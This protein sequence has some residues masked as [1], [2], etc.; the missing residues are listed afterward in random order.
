MVRKTPPTKWAISWPSPSKAK[1][2]QAPASQSSGHFYTFQK[3][4]N[5]M[6]SKLQLIPTGEMSREAWLS[7]RHTGLGASEVGCILGLDDYTSSLELYYYKIGEVPKFD[8]ESMASFIGQIDE[9]KIAR[10]WQYWEG[11]EE[12]MIRNF[13]EN[14]IVRRCQRVNAYVRNPDYPWLYISLDRKINKHGDLDE[15]TLELKTIGGWEANKWEAGLPPKYI[16]QVQTQILVAEFLYGEMALLEDNRKFFVYPIERN[17]NIINHIITRTKDFWDRVEKGRRL[18]NEKYDAMTKFNQR[19]VDECTHEIDALAPEPDGT[20]AYSDYLKKRFDKP[21]SAE[22]KGTPSELENA[23]AQRDAADRLKEVTETKLLHENV[24]K[25]SMGDICQVLDFG[26]DGKVYWS[27]T[28]T[29]SRIFRNKLK[30]G[31]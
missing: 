20:L 2:L 21:S 8:T 25:K 31:V 27:K 1:L 3:T 28:S 15:G 5:V 14:K 29:G 19:R 12:S 17:E 13:R 30:T 9:D 23:I 7:Y 24:L 10:L 18:V 22:R 6:K 11:D 4:T 26:K 16:T